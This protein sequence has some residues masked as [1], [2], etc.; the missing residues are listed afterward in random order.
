MMYPYVSYLIRGM[1]TDKKS[2]IKEEGA[3]KG[4]REII[5][6]MQ[7]KSGSS[8]IFW[9]FSYGCWQCPLLPHAAEQW[10]YNRE[11]GRLHLILEL[12]METV[13]IAETV[14]MMKEAGKAD[15]TLVAKTKR[16]RNFVQL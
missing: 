7:K 4:R 13:G 16:I 10:S 12:T 9:L 11:I 14:W 1:F 15:I 8:L 5:E 6:I 2:N 3:R